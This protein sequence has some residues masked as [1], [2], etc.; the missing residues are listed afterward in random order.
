MPDTTVQTQQP[1]S[2]LRVIGGVVYFLALLYLFFFSIE[3][4]STAFRMGGRGFAEQLLNTAADPVAGLIIGFLATSLIQSSSTTTTIVVGL[5]ASN[6]LHDP[7]RDPHN[8]GCEHRDDD[9][10]H[11]RVHRPRNT[12][13]GV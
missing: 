4:M 7:A 1:A 2:P 13:G 3:L 9:H 5:V 11:H 10:Q 12:T 6:A 8:H